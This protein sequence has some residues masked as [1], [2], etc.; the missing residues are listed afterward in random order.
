MRR[1]AAK[2]VRERMTALLAQLADEQGKV[3]AL[4]AERDALLLRVNA[5]SPNYDSCCEERDRVMAENA[6]LKAET[7]RLGTRAD[8]AEAARAEGKTLSRWVRD[9]LLLRAAAHGE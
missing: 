9:T 2:Q 3:A 7:W 1:E 8:E 5:P 4:T 6:A